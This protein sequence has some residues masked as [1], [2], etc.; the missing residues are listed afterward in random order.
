MIWGYL[1]FWK[2]P[3][4]NGLEKAENFHQLQGLFSTIFLV[5][6]PH[7]KWKTPSWDP[8]EAA[9]LVKFGKYFH[10]IFACG[11]DFLG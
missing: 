10:P 6:L 2:P 9:I 7:A 5:K 4:G 8:R 1:Y 11:I 3:Y